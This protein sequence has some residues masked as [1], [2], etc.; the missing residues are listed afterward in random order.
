METYQIVHQP[1]FTHSE[2]KKEIPD[3]Y[4]KRFTV[5]IPAY[6]EE[7]RISPVLNDICRFISENK[8]PWDVIVAIDGN[9]STYDIAVNFAETYDFI[10]I[11]RS[12]ER[13]GKGGAIKRVLPK[14]DGE[15]TIIMDADNSI[16]FIDIVEAIQRL[17]KSDAVILSRYTGKN[18]IPLLR[19]F[20][21]RGFN[22]IVRSI[23]GLSV[24]D[25]QSGYKLFRSDFFVGAM[26]RV[27]VTNASYD[28][29]LLYHIKK[30]GGR[31]TETPAEYTHADDG[32]LNPLSMAMSFGISLVAFRIRNSPLYA[33]IP[34]FLVK[35]Y[36]RKFRWI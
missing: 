27:T 7:K 35:L 2:K 36:H 13:S 29:A 9:D 16:G 22:I 6:N 25:T 26:R 33:H 28:V 3:I 20:L 17:E 24:S 19:R 8:L 12:H 23:T 30:M 1:D 32:K 18:K 5:I 34:Q 31:I 14:I 4:L 11:D 21:S 10:S 15:F